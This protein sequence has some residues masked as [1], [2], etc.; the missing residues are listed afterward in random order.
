MNFHPLSRHHFID[1]W[2]CSRN[3]SR[4]ESNFLFGHNPD[5]DE[6]SA[7]CRKFHLRPVKCGLVADDS[8]SRRM[9][10][11]PYS[12]PADAEHGSIFLKSSS[13]RIQFFEEVREQDETRQKNPSPLS[14][15][16]QEVSTVEP[17]V[18]LNTELLSVSTWWCP[19]FV[20]CP[21]LASHPSWCSRSSAVP[22]DR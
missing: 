5:A 7:K 14:H 3:C 6:V 9:G 11:P 18:A 13:R 4:G 20:S 22:I 15:S 16:R 10:V 19:A 17:T 8:A 21:G 1:Y 2:K 12:S